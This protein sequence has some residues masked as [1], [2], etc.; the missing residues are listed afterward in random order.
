MRMS[1]RTLLGWIEGNNVLLQFTAVGAAN[2]GKPLFQVPAFEKGTNRFTDNSPEKSKPFFEVLI[3]RV[4]KRL[5]AAIE[6]L[7][8]RG[9]LSVPGLIYTEY[10]HDL[11][12]NKCP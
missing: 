4:L 10:R 11:G 3:V 2:S 5:V 8:Q 9:G 12:W 7:P 1:N 6:D